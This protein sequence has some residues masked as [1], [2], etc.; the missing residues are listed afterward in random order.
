MFTCELS[1]IAWIPKESKKH[2]V[3]ST[4]KSKL[5][6][7]CTMTWLSLQPSIPK[8][9]KCRKKIEILINHFF[10]QNQ[11][12]CINCGK[13]VTTFCYGCL[14]DTVGVPHMCGPDKIGSVC[15]NLIHDIVSRLSKFW[16][17]QYSIWKT[18]RNSSKET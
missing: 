6:R 3:V 13:Y 18:R 4:G 14:L 5:Q 9:K 15:W 7:N 16:T 2:F 12:H 17:S 8:W 11:S 10:P 1:C